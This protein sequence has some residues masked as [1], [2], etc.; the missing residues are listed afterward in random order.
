MYN[1]KSWKFAE[2]HFKC[3]KDNTFI[4]TTIKAHREKGSEK[5]H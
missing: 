5:I 1:K 4:L 2:H 3:H